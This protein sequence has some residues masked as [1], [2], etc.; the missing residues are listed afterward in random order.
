VKV[1]F[2]RRSEG[3]AD[4]VSPPQTA[5]RVW[6][7]AEH[8]WPPPGPR[9]LQNLV[10]WAFTALGLFPRRDFAEVS[11]WREGRLLHRLIVTP[12]WWR[13]PFMARDDL[14]IGDLWTDPDFRGQG[15]ARAAIAE[16]H[17]RFPDRFWYVVGVDNAA[18]IRLIESCGYRL[19]GQGR[20][21]RPL[22]V[23]AVG[24]FL[25]ET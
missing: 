21:T 4:A 18:S 7:P 14:Q 22:G 25:L 16:A 10:W 5:A 19:V 1:L 12:R 6:R 2:Y 3:A 24:R 20:R 23:G 8:G 9:R 15:F 17:R 13:F 11:L